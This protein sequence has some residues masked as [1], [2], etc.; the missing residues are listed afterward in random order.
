[1][2]DSWTYTAPVVASW[3]RA[4]SVGTRRYTDPRHAEA[5]ECHRFHALAARPR[6]WR[7]DG[8]YTVAVYY[9][10]AD[11]RRRDADRVLSLVLDALIGV[12]Y[13]DDADRYLSGCRVE[14]VDVGD[15]TAR[16]PGTTRVVVTRIGDAPPPTAARRRRRA[17]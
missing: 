7:L 17:T 9:T 2:S 8:V 4:R 12:A 16:D 13:E 10:P 14:R 5:R 11:G 6:G 1:M 3:A 15:D